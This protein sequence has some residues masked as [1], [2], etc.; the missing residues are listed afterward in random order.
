MRNPASVGLEPVHAFPFEL[1]QAAG[2]IVYQ[3]G[4]QGEIAK[5]ACEYDR[6]R[7]RDEP[8]VV[9]DPP[10]KVTRVEGAWF[11]DGELVGGL[12]RDRP[13][14]KLRYGP[15]GRVLRVY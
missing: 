11:V 2:T 1:D 13:A 9:H 14:G 4:W 10:P 5:R 7:K 15:P 3:D 12:H 6:R 8:I